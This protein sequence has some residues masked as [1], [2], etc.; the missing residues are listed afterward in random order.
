MD[1][2][3]HQN[4]SSKKDVQNSEQAFGVSKKMIDPE[5]VE[6]LQEHLADALFN[7]WIRDIEKQNN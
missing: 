3:N 5:D 4:L 2:S 7:M 6:I 1:C